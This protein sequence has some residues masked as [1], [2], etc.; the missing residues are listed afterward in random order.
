M[1]VSDA[2]ESKIFICKNLTG[3]HRVYYEGT[4]LDGGIFMG[5]KIGL[6]KNISFFKTRIIGFATGISLW[7]TALCLV[8]GLIGISFAQ[9][10]DKEEKSAQEQGQSAASVK[11]ETLRGKIFNLYGREMGKVDPQGKIFNAYGS[12]LGSVD[13]SGTIFNV[14]NIIIGKV[15]DDGI[16][17]NQS[18]TVLGSVNEKGEIFNVS[19]N[20]LGEVRGESDIRKIGA[21]GRLIFFRK[22]N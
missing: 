6:N 14:S 17:S 11:D 2:V 3:H 12:N 18:G 15:S 13:I 4:I 8:T 5:M 10:G 19:G 7:M 1:G 21:A 20:K 16:I 22:S 9:D